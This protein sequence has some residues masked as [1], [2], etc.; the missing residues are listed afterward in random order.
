M[1]TTA[2]DMV[3]PRRIEAIAGELADALL[4]QY[5]TIGDLH[6]LTRT[7]YEAVYNLG[8]NQYNQGKYLDAARTFSFLT[9]HDHLEPRFHKALGACLQML[10]QYRQAVA[11]QATALVLD[12]TDPEPMLRIGE[13]MIALG[14]IADAQ[15]VLE[16]ARRLC[17]ETGT[18]RAIGERTEALLE[19]LANASAGAERHP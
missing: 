5:L 9:F 3:E 13:C 19:I 4:N 6:G 17:A 1:T 7:D 12:A 11:S 18:H 15:E 14:D 8:Y 16:G 2:P 10:G